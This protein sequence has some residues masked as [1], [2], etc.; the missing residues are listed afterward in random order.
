MG[1]SVGSNPVLGKIFPIVYQSPF[2]PYNNPAVWGFCE[3]CS[4]ENSKPDI[5]IFA[6]EMIA[7]HLIMKLNR[8]D[9]VII[10][11]PLVGDAARIMRG[12]W[13]R[14]YLICC[15]TSTPTQEVIY[16]PPIDVHRHT[17]EITGE[18]TG[19]TVIYSRAIRLQKPQSNHICTVGRKEL[20][21]VCLVD[22]CAENSVGN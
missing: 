10:E 18:L 3:S 6:N 20:F 7:F 8:L 21:L 4:S 5:T 1:R 14:C 11:L 12:W 22:S 2:P 9:L 17:W 15:L 13:F 19:Y 16:Q